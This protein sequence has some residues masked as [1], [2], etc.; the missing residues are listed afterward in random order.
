M[1]SASV[2]TLP[3]SKVSPSC[4]ALG[5][6][7][8]AMA[9]HRARSA[10]SPPSAAPAIASRRSKGV[11]PCCVVLDAAP[12]P[13]AQHPT[14]FQ[15][16]FPGLLLYSAQQRRS[17]LRARRC[18]CVRAD[19]RVRVPVCMRVCAWG[20]GWGRVC[21]R[22]R[23]WWGERMGGGGMRGLCAAPCLIR[24]KKK[25][26]QRGTPGTWSEPTVHGNALTHALKHA[27]MHAHTR[28]VSPTRPLT[29]VYGK[30]LSTWGRVGCGAAGAVP[31]GAAPQVP[32]Q[33]RRRRRCRGGSKYGG[34]VGAAEGRKHRENA[35]P[36]INTDEIMC[37][38]APATVLT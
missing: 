34:A 22:A 3:V 33:R 12:T 10:A 37:C 36:C 8:I 25:I 7:G 29:T 14:F 19:V 6:A 31:L 35:K 11:G 27:L 24:L 16:L 1:I 17:P 18:G 23:V 21:V 20:V 2:Q 38:N 30:K 5:S 15:V 13:A 9:S 28:T 32:L 4:A 26:M